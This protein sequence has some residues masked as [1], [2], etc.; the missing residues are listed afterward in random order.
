M[1]T[2]ARLSFEEWVEL[3]QPKKNHLV[4]N[5][6]FQD[7]SGVGTM[8]ETYGVE[9]DWVK[10]QSPQHVWT[11]IDTEDGTAIVSGYSYVNRIGYFI[12]KR[13]YNKNRM[14]YVEVINDKAGV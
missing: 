6:S 12:T 8:F 11:Y 10:V 5:A 13:P 9:L 3:Y 7:E 14:I 1:R 2:K 4:E